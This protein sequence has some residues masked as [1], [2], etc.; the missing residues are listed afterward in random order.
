MVILTVIPG[1]PE[2]SRMLMP[3]RAANRAT[4]YKP[5]VGSR[6]SPNTGGFANSLL[7]SA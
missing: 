4:T 2:T 1:T 6:A 5:N 7:S 3:C